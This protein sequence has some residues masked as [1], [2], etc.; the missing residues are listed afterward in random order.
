MGWVIMSPGRKSDIVSAL[1]SKKS[2][3]D[4]EKL[5]DTDVLGLKESH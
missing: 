2:V 1:F 5:W 4:Y 3:N